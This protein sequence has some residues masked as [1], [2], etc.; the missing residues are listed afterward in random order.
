MDGILKE[1]SA[2]KNR[3]EGAL[4]FAKV[5]LGLTGLAGGTGLIAYIAQLLGV[6]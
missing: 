4:G 1:N 5:L 2:L 3:L 6:G